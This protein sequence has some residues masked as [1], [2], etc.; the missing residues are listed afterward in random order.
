MPGT[1]NKLQEL[2]VITMEECGEL[3]QRCSKIIRKFETL[4]EITEDQR[5]K[6]LEEVGDVQCL[7]ELMVDCGL[8]TND[9]INA[10]IDS[11]RNKLKT[12]SKLIK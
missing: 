8:L 10:R 3:T 1:M 2:M 11:K 5:V 9:E 6:L 7:I 4:E 12:W